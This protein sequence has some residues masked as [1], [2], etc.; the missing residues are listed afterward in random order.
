MAIATLAECYNNHGIFTGVV[1]IRRGLSA[2]I[3]CEVKDMGSFAAWTMHFA[4]DLATKV[5]IQLFQVIFS[6][7]CRLQIS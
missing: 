7:Y 5:C 4:Q 3:A 6:T 1:K 2:R